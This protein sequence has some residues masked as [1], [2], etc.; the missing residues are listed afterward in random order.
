MSLASIKRRIVSIESTAKI[1]NA[2]KLIASSKLA[3]QTKK[4]QQNKDYFSE[5]YQTI[6]SLLSLVS[7]DELNNFSHEANNKTL[8]I[9]VSSNLGLCGGYNVNLYKEVQK[10]AKDDDYFVVFGKR[11]NEHFKKHFPNAVFLDTSIIDVDKEISNEQCTLLGY[12]IFD[13]LL[14][15]QFKTIKACYTKFVNAITFQPTIIN[16]FPFD[17]KLQEQNVKKNDTSYDFEPNK[18][19]LVQSIIPEYISM[20][21][22]A[23]LNESIL[24]ECASR[25]NAMDTAT[26]N[27]TDLIT[28]YKLS[29]NR[30]RQASITNEIIEI[31]AGNEEN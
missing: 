3:K 19:K 12:E 6:G 1:T 14:K 22:Y 2:M 27:A 31:V 13:N 26:T 4:F 11:G 9:I 5:Y 15:G 29:Y 16:V 8:W 20:I 30:I 10:N 7:M 17:Q 18:I 23:S 28:K 25:R 21:I 24:S